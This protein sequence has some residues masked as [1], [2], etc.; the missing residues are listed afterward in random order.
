MKLYHRETGERLEISFRTLEDRDT[1]GVIACI[2]DEYGD[3]YFKRDFYNPKFI[4]DEH[5]EGIITFLVAVTDLEEVAGIMI[6]KKFF[7]YESMIEIATQIFKKKYR[8]YG[9]AEHMFDYGMKLLQEMPCSAVYSLPV[10]FHGI[11]QRLLRMRGLI[12]CG[13]IFS[14]F[15]MEKI[16]QSYGKRRN[17]KH[18]QGIQILAKDKTDAGTLYI[19]QE[20]RGFTGWLYKKLGVS[21]RLAAAGYGAGNG[22]DNAGD[23]DG[24]C[25]SGYAEDEDGRCGSGYA[26][27]EAGSC[28]HGYVENQ[29][30]SCQVMKTID[31][32][33]SSAAITIYKTGDGLKVYLESI[34]EEY[35]SL[36][37]FTLNVFLNVNDPGAVAAY[38]LL[39]EKGFFFAGYKP[40]CSENEYMVMHNP[41]DVP[42]IFKD[43]VLTEE[44]QDLIQ[45]ME[46]FYEE[47]QQRRGMGGRHDEDEA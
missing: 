14:V 1:D 24:R 21:F 40:L 41:L 18:S 29:D 34:L 4:W 12:G 28:V 43:Y 38:Y 6:L 2:R 25:R 15:D 30:V 44:F 36:P 46:V 16:Q 8:G 13:F 45:Y 23:E 47:R 20:Q 31:W 10:T 9:L 19:P 11:S 27:D 37:R 3:T 32:V 33:Q 42:I 17:L 35:G 7:P 26:G 22:S 5:R 39:K